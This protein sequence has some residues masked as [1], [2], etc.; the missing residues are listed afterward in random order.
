MYNKKILYYAGSDPP[1]LTLNL[2]SHML[3][4]L[5]LHHHHLLLLLDVQLAIFT[6]SP[7]LGFL[8]MEK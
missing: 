5:L 2:G 6:F 3:L 1:N 7:M 4:R 8:E